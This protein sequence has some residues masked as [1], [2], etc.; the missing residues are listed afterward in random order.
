VALTSADPDALIPPQ[1]TVTCGTV[2]VAT[3]VFSVPRG[4]IE[5]LE[6]PD[7]GGGETAELS[8]RMDMV[9]K[10][11]VQI[12]SSAKSF[13]A[14]AGK[15]FHIEPQAA[16]TLINSCR[17]SLDELSALR[18][19]LMTVAQTPKLGQTPGANVVAPFTQSAAVDVQGITPAIDNLQQTLTDMI[20]AYKTASTNYAETETLVQQSM[21]AKT[22][23]M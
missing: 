2:W 7:G 5:M 20:Q 10:Q 4:E 17:N 16:A 12:Q 3:S 15:G 22:R 23:A 13:A 8:A 18:Q 9:A 6:I 21:H 19:H 11:S 1:Q 14:A